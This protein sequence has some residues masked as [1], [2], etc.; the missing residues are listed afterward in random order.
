ML[1]DNTQEVKRLFQFES[2]FYYYKF[3]VLVRRKDY[4]EGECPLSCKEGARELVVHQ[5]LVS[6]MEEYE[7]VL[8]DMLAFAKA[9]K[10][11]LYV[12]TDRKDLRKSLVYVRNAVSFNLDQMLFGQDSVSC[13]SLFRVTSSASS[14]AETSSKESKCWLFDVDTKDQKVLKQVQELCKEYYL[15]TLETKSGYHVLAKK[16]FA[17]KQ[18]Q[19]P[20]DVELKENALTLVAAY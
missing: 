15:C 4:A 16:K 10:A 9:F 20:D 12:S 8:P 17:A 2:S 6:S 3:T 5:W 1:V 19:L 13:K 7:K 11:R 18:L 14:V